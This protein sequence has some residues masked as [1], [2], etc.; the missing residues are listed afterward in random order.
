MQKLGVTT[1][2]RVAFNK[3]DSTLFLL[4]LLNFAGSPLCRH[5]QRFDLRSGR[6]WQQTLRE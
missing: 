6:V 2:F 1:W 5:D 4:A 3:L